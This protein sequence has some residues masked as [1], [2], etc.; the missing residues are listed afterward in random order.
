M[1]GLLLLLVYVTF[2]AIFIAFVCSL[3]FGYERVKEKLKDWLRAIYDWT[4]IF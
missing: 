2:T 1:K 4:S 3:S